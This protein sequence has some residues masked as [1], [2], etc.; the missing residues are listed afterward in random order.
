MAAEENG[1][2]VYQKESYGLFHGWLILSAVVLTGYVIFEDYVQFE[3]AAK[4]VG[5]LVCILLDILFL[6]VFLKDS[7]YW[8]PGISYES[9]VQAGH[10]ARRKCAFIH[11]VVFLAATVLWFLYC[12]G[13]EK[14]LYATDITDSMTA[15]ALICVASWLSS[16]ARI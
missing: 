7:V 8:I 12:F 11:L 9:A 2:M 14:L 5:I 10:K 3:G 15:A 16:F 4:H 13:Q 6:L 1:N